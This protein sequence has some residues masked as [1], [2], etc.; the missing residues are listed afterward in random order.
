LRFGAVVKPDFVNRV[1]SSLH[2]LKERGN[3]W[4]FP[5]DLPSNIEGD[6]TI[7]CGVVVG[8]IGVHIPRLVTE[9]LRTMAEDMVSR[10]RGLPISEQ[11]LPVG[12]SNNNDFCINNGDEDSKAENAVTTG[13]LLARILCASGCAKEDR[14]EAQ[15]LNLFC[16]LDSAVDFAGTARL[17][18][19]RR[20]PI[21]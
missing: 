12:C 13:R 6:A 18:L 7:N 14:G 21:R 5:V 4:R 2:E 1:W 19:R 16:S 8:P 15:Q 20:P 10:G 9:E 3:G 11:V 17:L